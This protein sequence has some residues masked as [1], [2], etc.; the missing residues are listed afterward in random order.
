MSQRYALTYRVSI[1]VRLGRLNMGRR[2]SRAAVLRAGMNRLHLPEKEKCQHDA[3][4]ING[5]SQSQAM[6]ADRGHAHQPRHY[7]CADSAYA[8]HD[9]PSAARAI[10]VGE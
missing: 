6:H 5:D 8:D 4:K 9:G 3:D 1:G 7:R 2:A 10:S